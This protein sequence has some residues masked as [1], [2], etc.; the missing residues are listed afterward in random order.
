MV[1]ANLFDYFRKLQ[2]PPQVQDIQPTRAYYNGR[3]PVYFA[4][5]EQMQAEMPNLQMRSPQTDSGALINAA[6][7]LAVLAR[8]G[9]NGGRG[10]AVESTMAPV[11]S[12][13]LGLTSDQTQKMLAMGM[14]DK[15]FQAKQAE[16]QAALD[17]QAATENA[18]T[19]IAQQEMQ[20]RALSDAQRH[21]ETLDYHDMVL[22]NQEKEHSLAERRATLDEKKL[23]REA[24]MPKIDPLGTRG[25][26]MSIDPVTGL[27]TVVYSEADK[28]YN[29]ASVAHQR[30]LASGGSDGEGGGD[31]PGLGESETWFAPDGKTVLGVKVRAGKSSY[32]FFTNDG[33]RVGSEQ[34]PQYR[35]IMNA[36]G[37][38][39]TVMLPPNS[40]DGIPVQAQ[41]GEDAVPVDPITAAIEKGVP[42]GLRRDRNAVIPVL[43]AEIQAGRV[44]PALAKAYVDG[45][46]GKNWFAA[47]P[48]VTTTGPA[49]PTAPAPAPGAAPAYTLSD[50]KGPHRIHTLPNGE[51]VKVRP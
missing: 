41:G 23:D 48:N 7:Q 21:K 45:L 6:Q 10:G 42:D 20:Q 8:A 26:Y 13:V 24:K 18:R 31:T 46:P 29:D 12:G 39:T 47:E 22:K 44:D 40:A 11:Q 4:S 34:N 14:E 33:R 5:P 17:Q 25:S 38:R 50:E 51:Q 3:M 16:A 30:R 2:D 49:A 35:E 19:Q 43:N 32:Q 37:T 9:R 36:D 27:P 28:Q 15:Q 1:N